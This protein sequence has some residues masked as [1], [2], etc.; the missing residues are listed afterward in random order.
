MKLKDGKAV[1]IPVDDINSPV[2]V[3]EFFSQ[4]KNVYIKDVNFDEQGNPV[5]LYLAGPG[6]QPGPKNGPREW[7]VAYYNGSDWE[8]HKITESDQNYDTGSLFI[9]G[10]EWMV[11]GPSVDSPQQWGAGGEVVMWKS[12]DKGKT[13]E[14]AKQLTKDSDSNHNYI[15][16][17]VSGKDPFFYFWADGNPDKISESHLYFGNSKGRV[18]QLPYTMEKDEEKPKR[19]R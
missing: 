8:H 15:R 12:K 4:G 11:I 13:W 18:W 9:K 16:K 6:H 17:V 7:F 1:S 5:A 19:V 3:K 14:R 2:L 10:D